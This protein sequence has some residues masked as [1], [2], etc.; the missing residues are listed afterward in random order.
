MS[1]QFQFALM[2]LIRNPNHA[3]ALFTS[4]SYFRQEYS[5][6]EKE[7]NRLQFMLSQKGMG[8]NWLIYRIG[9][10]N[11]VMCRLPYTLELLGDEVGAVFDKYLESYPEVV[12]G[13]DT[14]A[15]QFADFLNRWLG[16]QTNQHYETIKRAL[17]SE[18]AMLVRY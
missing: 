18:Y 14:E 15:K 16:D 6:T 2:V 3:V 1:P 13:F 11:N 17:S 4:A 5:L 8:M 9:R 7:T 12:F 10:L